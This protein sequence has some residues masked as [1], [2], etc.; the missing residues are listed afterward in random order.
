MLVSVASVKAR[1]R[2]GFVAI[3]MPEHT[4]DRVT[5]HLAAASTANYAINING[6]P[7]YRPLQAFTAEMRSAAGRVTLNL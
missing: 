7:L 4:L 3:Y 6:K 5:A 2:W 1:E